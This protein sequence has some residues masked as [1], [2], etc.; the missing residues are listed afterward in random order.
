MR[1]L[2][3]LPRAVRMAR[4][5]IAMMMMILMDNDLMMSAHTAWLN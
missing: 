3:R 5:T 4:M 2:G 1:M